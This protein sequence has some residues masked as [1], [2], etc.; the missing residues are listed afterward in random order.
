VKLT[1]IL[2]RLAVLQSLRTVLEVGHVHGL[3]LRR[4]VPSLRW[5]TFSNPAS[6]KLVPWIRYEGCFPEQRS[7]AV[8]IISTH[9]GHMCG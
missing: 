5:Y 2:Q 6:C 3:R 8:V 1:P 4:I 9:F 7:I